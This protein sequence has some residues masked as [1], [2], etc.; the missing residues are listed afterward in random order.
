MQTPSRGS[1]ASHCPGL[2]L[3]PR[4]SCLD[5]PSLIYSLWELINR[6]LG[7]LKMEF[8]KS[9]A[10][11]VK[12]ALYK[13]LF[14]WLWTS[15]SEANP[16]LCFSLLGFSSSKYAAHACFRAFAHPALTGFLLA[17]EFPLILS[18]QLRDHF[19][20]EVFLEAQVRSFTLVH[21]GILSNYASS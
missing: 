3:Q 5:F 4:L 1:Q 17:W 19:L 20:Q 15:A 9:G 18:Y 14:W 10:G 2:P 12:S 8:F 16:S 7:L 11:L 6:I 21:H 13:L